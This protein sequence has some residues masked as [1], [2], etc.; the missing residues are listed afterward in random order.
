MCSETDIDVYCTKTDVVDIFRYSSR[1]IRGLAGFSK[2]YDHKQKSD[3]ETLHNI[4][5]HATTPIN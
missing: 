2:V 3:I 4:R 5:L 1:E